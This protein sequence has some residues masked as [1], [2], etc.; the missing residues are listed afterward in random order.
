MGMGDYCIIEPG[1]FLSLDHLLFKIV[2][3]EYVTSVLITHILNFINKSSSFDN[4]VKNNSY[5]H[6]SIISYYFA[7][8]LLL[9]PY[10]GLVE[11][12]ICLSL[13]SIV[14]LVFQLNIAF[15]FIWEF[16]VSVSER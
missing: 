3:V 11:W 9:A 5:Y 1:I 8:F 14:P 2:L 10:W 4:P 6:L 7:N 15:Q 16:V 12:Y 13:G